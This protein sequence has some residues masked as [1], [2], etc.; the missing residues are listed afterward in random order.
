[1]KQDTRFRERSAEDYTHLRPKEAA[2]YLNLSE[3]KLAKLRMARNRALGPRFIK[4]AGCVVYR[5]ADL[6]AW[7][8]AHVMK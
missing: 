2:R 8:E 3:S 4:L 6:D 1:M 7:L 5:R